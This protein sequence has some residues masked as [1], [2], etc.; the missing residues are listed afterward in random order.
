MPRTSRPFSPLRAVF[1]ARYRAARKTRGLTLDDVA[2]AAQIDWSYL[3]Q[4]ERGQRNVGI[5]VM[6]A[7]ARA[8]G[9]P[10]H[11]LLVPEEG[12]GEE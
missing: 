11:E 2:H 5:D 6:D 9:V 10:L 12:V 3:A 4:L 8:I 1:G 7:L